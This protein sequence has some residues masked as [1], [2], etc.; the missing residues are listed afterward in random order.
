MALPVLKADEM[1]QAQTVPD[2]VLE[3]LRCPTTQSRLRLARQDELAALNAAVEA[4][5]LCNALGQSIDE[6]SMA[7]C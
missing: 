6:R 4:G 5:R 7:R 3:V 2:F 1:E